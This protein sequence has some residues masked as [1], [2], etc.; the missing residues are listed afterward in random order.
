MAAT[1]ST[2]PILLIAS[3]REQSLEWMLGRNQYWVV[4]VHTGRQ[5]L[6][7]AR[8][9]RPDTIILADV[10][11]DMTGIAACQELSNEERIGHTVP[12]LILSPHPPTPEQRV[13]ALRAGAWDFLGY[14]GDPGELSLKLQTYVQAKRNIDRALAEGLESP[15]TGLQSRTVLA[16]RA[17][18]LGSL[19]S[20]KHGALACVVFATDPGAADPHA[21]DLVARAARLSDIVGALSSTEIAVVAPGTDQSGAVSLARRVGG[22]LRQRSGP[23]GLPAL[24]SSLRAGYEAVGNLAYSPVDPV[25]LLARA[26]AAVREGSPEPGYPWLRRLA[27]PLTEGPEMKERARATPPG[28]VFD[29]RRA[30]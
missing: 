5:A 7:R 15:A 14:P 18:E 27:P 9:V 30:R 21:G 22:A 13:A 28:I 10:L 17:R 29:E 11:P 4:E 25:S 1:P 8:D 23:S 24:G 20:R 2:K 6:E 26:A 16:R 19:L 3:S 12:I